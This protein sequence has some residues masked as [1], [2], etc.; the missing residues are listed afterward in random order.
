ML[1]QYDEETNE[2]KMT[3]IDK[4]KRQKVSKLKKS[5]LEER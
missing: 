5:I 3:L 4:K 1:V 2:K